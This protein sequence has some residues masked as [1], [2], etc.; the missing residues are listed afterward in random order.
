[1][2][3]KPSLIGCAALVT[4][5]SSTLQSQVPP[6]GVADQAAQLQSADAKL[7]ANK[8]LVYDMWRAIIQGGH[9]ELA[10]KYFTAGYIQHNPNVASGRDALVKFMRESRPLRP[11]QPSITFP[12][13]AML[14][15]RDLV[16]VA[17][18]SYAPDPQDASRRYASTHF[19]M[20]RIEDGKIAEHWDNLPKNPAL[21]HTDPNATN[22][23]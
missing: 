13:V 5:V 12:L 9:T 15:E 11:I 23:P 8:R 22:K 7:A 4:L 16:V 20:F 2:R 3:L 21:L 6:T 1:M 17:T 10:A 19:D 14:A 18:V